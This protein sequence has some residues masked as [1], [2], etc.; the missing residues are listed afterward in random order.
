MQAGPRTQGTQAGMTRNINKTVSHVEAEQIICIE[1]CT[2]YMSTVVY[3]GPQNATKSLTAG[4][5]HQTADSAPPNPLAEMRKLSILLGHDPFVKTGLRFVVK[6]VSVSRRKWI[7]SFRPVYFPWQQKVN[8]MA[9]D[10]RALLLLLVFDE[11]FEEYDDDANCT[12]YQ[13]NFL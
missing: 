10:C 7:I 4:A 8:Y 13:D 5:S 1:Q 3:L 11:M 12:G 6:P 2:F 9:G